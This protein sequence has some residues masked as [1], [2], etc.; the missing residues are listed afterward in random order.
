MGDDVE[1][2]DAAPPGELIAEY[3]LTEHEWYAFVRSEDGSFILRFARVCDFVVS[4]D[5]AQAEVRL[6]RG[7]RNA[8]MPVFA[9]GAL[10]SFVLVMSFQP[11]LH[12]SAVNVGDGVVAFVGR[13]GMGKS[14][15]ATLWCASGAILVTDDVLRL[16]PGASPRC[17]LGPR[18]LRLRPAVREL[19][20][21]FDGEAGSS[22]T[23][24]GRTAV[25]FT[26][27]A[28]ELAPLEAVVVP[29]PDRTADKPVVTRLAPLQACTALLSYPRLLGWREAR[30]QAAQ[31]RFMADVAAS[32]P[33]YQVRVPWGPP[34]PP[35]LVGEVH[36]AFGLP[37]P[38]RARHD[39]AMSA[40]A[41]A[42]P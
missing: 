26:Q 39:H 16:T 33:V 25:E 35:D 37:A 15:M 19:A 5:L 13:S 22:Q 41:N 14:T 11:L 6:D 7:G 27:S 21:W 29:L 34:F 10:P 9:A 17:Y 1:L 38:R 20:D 31:F 32:V 3:R 24:D 18:Q 40:G 36:G 42:V 30:A 4:P 23:G 8:L 12:A 2:P 28:T